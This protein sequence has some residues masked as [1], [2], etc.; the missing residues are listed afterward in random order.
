VGYAVDI[1]VFPTMVKIQAVRI[2][3]IIQEWYLETI[4]VPFMTRRN[5]LGFAKLSGRRKLMRRRHLR[6]PG[7]VLA[8]G[9]L[10]EIA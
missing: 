2:S 6:G 3:P 10:M 7:E 1:Y 9:K 4:V 8:H 5:N